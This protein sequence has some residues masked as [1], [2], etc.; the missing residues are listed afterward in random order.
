MERDKGYRRKSS[1]VWS[2][3]IIKGGGK[4][5]F[6]SSFLMIMLMFN[7]PKSPLR[8]HFPSKWPFVDQ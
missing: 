5:A 1:L 4:G 8:T 2:S 3:L 7:T 6:L